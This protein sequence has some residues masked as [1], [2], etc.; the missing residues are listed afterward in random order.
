MVLVL[1]AKSLEEGQI[2]GR[3]PHGTRDPRRAWTV[4]KERFFS[5]GA[6]DEVGRVS[7]CWGK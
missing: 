1:D 3:A 4:M 5:C 6:W 2:I 7:R